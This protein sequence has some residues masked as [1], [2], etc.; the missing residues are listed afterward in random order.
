MPPALLNDVLSNNLI[1]LSGDDKLLKDPENFP[2]GR[3]GGGALT[4]NFVCQG[5]GG[6][7][8]ICDNFTM[9]IKQNFI[10]QG[11]RVKP[12]PSL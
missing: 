12:P 5:E 2:L 1:T 3:R 11:E 10:F 9:D 4:D 8:H 7:R 6:S